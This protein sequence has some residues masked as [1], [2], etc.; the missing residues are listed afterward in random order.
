MERKILC[1]DYKAFTYDDTLTPCTAKNGKWDDEAAITYYHYIQ[2]YDVYADTAWEGPDGKKTPSL[3][4]MNWVDESGNPMN[5]ACYTGGTMDGFQVFAFD[6]TARFGESTDIV[7]HEFTHCFTNTTMTGCLYMNDYGA[8]NEGMSDI[9]GNLCAMMTDDQDVAFVEGEALQDGSER[10]M[11]DPHRGRQPAFVWDKFYVPAAA[12]ITEMND[13]GGVH[14]NS[15]L[16]NLISYRLY[17]AGMEPVDQFYYWMN[18]SDAMTPRTDYEQL[19]QILPWVMRT[20]GHENYAEV[21]EKAVK[22]TGIL[23]HEQPD[24]PADGLGIVSF[25]F[26]DMEKLSKYDV[27]AYFIDANTTDFKPYATWPAAETKVVAAALPEGDYRLGLT[28]VDHENEKSLYFNYTNQGWQISDEDADEEDDVDWA[29]FDEDFDPNNIIWGD[30]DD[31]WLMSDDDPEETG[32]D[33]SA[34]NDMD[35]TILH[36]TSGNTTVLDVSDLQSLLERSVP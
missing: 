36:V 34:G 8:I 14:M 21:I 31:D 18:V 24:P 10:Y 4:L 32:A 7:G 11:G 3:L 22:E 33:V 23:S 2:V 25:Q 27:L 19:G 17:E 13:N 16:L 20:F 29:E 15:S 1:A 9:L 28:V 30:F 26:P 6:T 5:N 35:I 12:E